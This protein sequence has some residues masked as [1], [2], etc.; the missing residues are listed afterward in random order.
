MG[1]RAGFRH[2]LAIVGQPPQDRGF[3]STP[4]PPVIDPSATLEALCQ[5]DAG[6]R[7]ATY[8]GPDT[9]LMK[10]AHVGHD[11]WVGGCCELPPG[12]V[13]CGWAVLGGGNRLG[14]GALVLPYKVLG[15]GA[16]VG[17]G[18]VVTHHVPPHEVWAG[19]PARRLASSPVYEGDT[20]WV[21]VLVHLADQGSI[22]SAAS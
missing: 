10:T 13:I 21:D 8:I 4:V 15:P 11:A 17:A 20:E 14:V 5:V 2:T 1:R 16:R 9:W 7:R 12:V 6:T 22:R 18:S 3:S 19:N